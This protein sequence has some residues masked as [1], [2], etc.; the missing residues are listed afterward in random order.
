VPVGGEARVGD[1]VIVATMGQDTAEA[2]R[3][4]DPRIVVASFQNGLAPLEALAGRR[5]LPAMVYVPAERRAPGV[6]AL[7]GVPCV[8][9]VLVG[10]EWLVGKL[11]EAGFRAEVEPDILPWIRGKLLTNLG[12]IVAA[13][14]DSRVDDVIEAAQEE[15]RAVWRANRDAFV[16][17]DALMARVGPLSVAPVDGRMRVG[18]STRAALARGDA[19]ETACLHGPIVARG[20]EVG[21]ATPVNARLIELADRAHR[22]RW[23]PGRL[24]AEELRTWIG[25]IG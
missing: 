7:P 12:G 23:A 14:C 13:L 21:V 3:G 15:A 22:E 20:R 8:G 18:G 5:L 1:L 24:G 10:S 19:L 9:T 11:R 25:S 4:L 6:I 16:E 17:I 2:V